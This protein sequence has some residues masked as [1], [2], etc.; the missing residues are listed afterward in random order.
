MVSMTYI[1]AAA[2]SAIWIV[3]IISPYAIL[4][5]ARYIKARFRKKEGGNHATKRR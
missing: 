3:G 1:D 4:K 2:I 5:V